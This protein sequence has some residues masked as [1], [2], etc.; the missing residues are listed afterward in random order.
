MFRSADLYHC[1]LPWQPSPHDGISSLTPGRFSWVFFSQNYAI[2][3]LSAKKPG[4]ANRTTF[5][6]APDIE[7][8]DDDEEWR[9]IEDEEWEVK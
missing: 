9:G 2:E 5:G 6:L 8:G 7:P 3:M 4:W 1:V